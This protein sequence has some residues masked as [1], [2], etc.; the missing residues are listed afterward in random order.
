MRNVGIARLKVVQKDQMSIVCE[1]YGKAPLQLHQPVYL[2]KKPYPTVFLK[3]PSSGLLDGDS[4]ILDVVVEENASLTLKTQAACLI[5]PGQSIQEI[6]IRLNE[7]SSLQFLPHPLIFARSAHLI[8]KIRIDMQETSKLLFGESW[9]AGRIAMSEKWQF[10][11]FD[12]TVEI[13]VGQR[14]AFKERFNLLP[15]VNDPKHDLRFG[16]YTAFDTIF[17]FD[18]VLP[19]ID[20]TDH[21]RSPLEELSGQLCSNPATARTFEQT[22]IKQQDQMSQPNERLVWCMSRQ[23]YKISRVLG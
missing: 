12:N 20:G 1:Q 4:H 9:R 16:K 6:R 11:C 17:E 23:N 7:N 5:Y 8:Q 19:M 15:Q 10:D 14:L 18:K 13:F 3:T 22:S 21:T 2:Q